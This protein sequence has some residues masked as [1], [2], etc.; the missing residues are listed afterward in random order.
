MLRIGYHISIAGS[1]DLA[2]DRAAALGCT[3]MQIFVTNPREWALRAIQEEEVKNFTK[4][5]RTYDVKPVCVH[6]PYLPNLASSDKDISEKSILSLKE[7]IERCNKLKI[8]YLVTHLGSH[9]GHGREQG[10]KNV[11]KALESASGDAGN[12]MILL[13]NQAGHLNSIGARLE[14]LAY[15]YKN[16]SL[17]ETGNLGFCLDTCHLF[18]AG[19]DVRKESVLRQIDQELGFEKVH[20]LHFNDAMFELG[21]GKDRHHNIGMGQIGIEGF[22]TMLDYDELTKKA[23]ILETPENPA[24]QEGEELRIIQKIAMES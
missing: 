17:T 9:M 23:L 5:S 13:E 18:A 7:N 19:Y 20:A 3:A 10:L 22:R 12:V 11:I 4:K 14:D 24:L 16:S 2:F 1:L 15:I 8:K 21:S 6:M